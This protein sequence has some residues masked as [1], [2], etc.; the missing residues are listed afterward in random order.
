MQPPTEPE[1]MHS[2]GL[3]LEAHIA[4]M[5]AALLKSTAATAVHGSAQAGWRERIVAADSSA[6]DSSTALASYPPHSA[7]QNTYYD[8]LVKNTVRRAWTTAWSDYQSGKLYRAP[9]LGASASGAEAA[10]AS[11]AQGGGTGGPGASGSGSSREPL[12]MPPPAASGRTRPSSG[13][14][15]AASTEQYA[16]LLEHPHLP[17]TNRRP[18]VSYSDRRRPA[19]G[20]RGP[21]GPPA[22]AQQKMRAGWS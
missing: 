15:A 10:D 21:V 3:R 17:N 7:S 20:L 13:G 2:A 12:R 1:S 14:T 6:A 18:T 19:V 11:A 22:P 16:P 8:E 4:S 9:I 5:R